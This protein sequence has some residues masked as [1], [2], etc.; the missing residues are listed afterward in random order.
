MKHVVDR[1]YA[2]MDEKK[3]TLCI[4]LDPNLRL[5]PQ[6]LLD[7]VSERYNLADNPQNRFKAA[8]E[9]IRIFNKHTI[10]L[11]HDLA[12]AYKPQSAYY[13][14]YG[15]EGVRVLEETIQYAKKMGVIVILDAK[16]NDIGATSQAYAN[17]HLGNVLF[18][19]GTNDRNI[20]DADMMTV[21]GYLGT[22][23]IK[24]FVDV[25]NRDGKGLFI[26]AKTSNPSAGELQDLQTE[27]GQP[28]YVRMARLIQEW[29]EGNIGDL[30]FSNIG[31]VVGATKPDEAAI[32][33]SMLP[34]TLFLLPGYGA[35]G[36]KGEILVNG[37][38]DN[39]R[40]ALVSSS[41]GITYAFDRKEFKARH[42]EFRKKDLFFSA[43]RQ[44][45]LDAIADI[46]GALERAGKLPR[47]WK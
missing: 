45:T 7:G 40:G 14:Q 30:G 29:G 32:L 12:V 42:P 46:N 11:T 24:P 2:A 33:R 16:R 41:R 38:D 25:A 20:A 43:A 1:L 3:S 19:D 6:A 37:F 15:S 31:A 22:D 47:S 27:D 9:A 10:N 39:G 28:V 17:A 26:L 21:N 44:A 34:R 23:G 35:Q 36:A 4:G 5:F 13:E 8:A 18:P